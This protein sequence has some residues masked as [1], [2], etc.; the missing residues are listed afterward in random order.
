MPSH[1]ALV[2]DDTG[3]FVLLLHFCHHGDISPCHDGLSNPGPSND[4]H[5]SIMPDLL[6]AHGLTGCDTVAQCCGIAKSVALKVLHSQVHSLSHLGDD[7]KTLE[8]V[9]KQATAF[10]LAC[11]GHAVLV[12]LNGRSLT[13]SVDLKR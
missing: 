1:K 12:S 3:V 4:C 5:S 2:A 7:S 6:A 13:E 9:M 11:Y 8:D 10:M